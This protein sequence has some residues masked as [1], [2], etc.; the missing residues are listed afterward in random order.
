[1]VQYDG[2]DLWMN[3]MFQN[4]RNGVLQTHSRHSVLLK[5]F[6]NWEVEYLVV[7]GIA[8]HCHCPERCILGKDLDLLVS[9]EL[10]N[11]VRIACALDS[12]KKDGITI[13]ETKQELAIRF[14][15]P[16]SGLK[17]EWELFADILTSSEEFDFNSAFS[18]SI[19]E[20]IN[21]IR[22]RIVPCVDLVHLK[23]IAYRR[24]GIE[25]DLDDLAMLKRRCVEPI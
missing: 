25:K 21:G 24:D 18:N 6:N 7:G 16:N 20:E 8:V 1:M 22:V 14:S 2:A 11:A 19:T 15:K 5:T 12:L 3:L 10:D 9:H 17:S 13:T 23:E 4:R